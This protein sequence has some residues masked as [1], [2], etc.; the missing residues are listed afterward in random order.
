MGGIAR[1]F[2]MEDMT[3]SHVCHGWMGKTDVSGMFQVCD[4][5]PSYGRH[6]FIDSDG[7]ENQ[8]LR[9]NCTN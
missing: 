1:V 7:A 9:K 5:N 2:D 3:R 6:E 4:M 8:F